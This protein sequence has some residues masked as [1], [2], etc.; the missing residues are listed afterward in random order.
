MRVC[1]YACVHMHV[2][3]Y[4]CTVFVCAHTHIHISHMFGYPKRP[5]EVL[6]VPQN[7]D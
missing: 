7:R 3:V 4:L 1:A 2:C 5:E 6:R